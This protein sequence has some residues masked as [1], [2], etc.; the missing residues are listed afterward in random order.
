M[1]MGY[2]SK[3]DNGDRIF[4]GKINGIFRLVNMGWDI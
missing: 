2:L 3:K 1:C 4:W